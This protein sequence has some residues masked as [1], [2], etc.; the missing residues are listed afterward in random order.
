MLIRILAAALGLRDWSS[1]GAD[2]FDEDFDP[3]AS[4]SIR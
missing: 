1:I 2:E 3:L 4:W